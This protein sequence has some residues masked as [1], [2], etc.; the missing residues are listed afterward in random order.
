MGAL[1]V[2]TDVVVELLQAEGVQVEAFDDA[3]IQLWRGVVAAV[4]KLVLADEGVRDVNAI[5]G[6]VDF[7]GELGALVDIRFVMVADSLGDHAGQSP[8]FTNGFSH[9]GVFGEDLFAFDL[10]NGFVGV[11]ALLDDFEV[12]LGVQKEVADLPMSWR[13]AVV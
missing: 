11:E 13:R 4:A 5:D 3:G 6:V 12:A 1:D 7:L 2:L 10:V 8:M 9:A